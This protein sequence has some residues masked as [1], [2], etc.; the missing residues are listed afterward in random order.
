MQIKES[1]Y[2]STEGYETD[3]FEEIG[4]VNKTLIFYAK[5]IGFAILD[6]YKLNP[7]SRLPRSP[8]KNLEVKI[9]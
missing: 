6:M 5:G 3:G 7:M 1:I 4:Q 8:Y 2:P 9:L